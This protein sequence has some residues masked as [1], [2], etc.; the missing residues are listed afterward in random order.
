MLILIL[1][2][3]AG[4]LGGWAGLYLGG[5]EAAEGTEKLEA[6]A[7]F[8]SL[9]G[10]TFLI[11]QVATGSLNRWF[12]EAF[13]AAA[14]LNYHRRAGVIIILAFLTHGFI[15]TLGH[16]LE[17]GR[18]L[19]A[20]VLHSWTV[21]QLVLGESAVI[22]L[23]VGGTA[24]F[25]GWIKKLPRS[26]WKP[27]H[28]LMYLAVPLGLTHAIT[29]THDTRELPLVAVWIYLVAAFFILAWQRRQRA[30]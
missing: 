15:H 20:V 14:L 24:A 5:G 30:S 6:T 2:P 1:L 28:Y 9:T 3:L 10:I 23:L 8:L 13:G 7:N 11:L 16:S 27:V 12:K 29:I 17:S 18:P 22:L 21:W 19:L 25:L 26:T 4:A